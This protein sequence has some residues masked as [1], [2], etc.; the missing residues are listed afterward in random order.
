MTQLLRTLAF[1]FPI[2]ILGALPVQAKS[3]KGSGSGGPTTFGVSPPIFELEG[4]PG[5]TV[6]GTIKVDNPLGV[7]STYKIVPSGVVISGSAFATK[8]LSSLPADHLS[9]NLTVDSPTL[10]IPSRSFKTVS[11][12]IKIPPTATGMQ[13][14]GVTI[15]RL[16]GGKDDAALSRSSEY[17]R[18][19]G[20]GMEPAIGITIKVAMKGG[21]SYS[22]KLDAV[23]VTPGTG[24]RPP[25]AIA[26]IRNTGN[27]ELRINPILMLVD[28]GGKV[29][30]RLKSASSVTLLPGAKQEVSFESQGRDIPGGSYKA[31]LSV[32]DTKYQLAPTELPVTVK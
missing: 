8:P 6:T 5:Q 24:S 13:Y 1:I 4:S 11:F 16:P 7:P 22:Y 26:T 12:T 20:L 30:I 15:S 23:K 21:T 32:P 27:G 17:E 9:R 2:L 10:S 25:M 19:M 31:V 18:H 29:G 28:A 14:A 3:G